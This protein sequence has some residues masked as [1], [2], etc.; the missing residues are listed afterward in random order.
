MRGGTTR[1]L[2]AAGQQTKENPPSFHWTGWW[3]EGEAD[4]EYRYSQYREDDA[5]ADVTTCR[6]F[7]L[8]PQVSGRFL[9]AQLDRCHVALV[10]RIANF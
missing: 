9:L 5:S 4:H 2:K 8:R 6:W 10:E 1:T 3:L 7:F